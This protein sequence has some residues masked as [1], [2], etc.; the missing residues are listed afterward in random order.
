MLYQN[1][2][3]IGTGYYYVSD[4]E[5]GKIA[6]NA[7]TKLPPHGYVLDLP[8]HVRDGLRMGTGLSLV[9]LIRVNTP[10]VKRGWHWAVF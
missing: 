8:K 9:A 10:N 4:K 2:D 5:A 1:Y 6:R 7:N 3:H